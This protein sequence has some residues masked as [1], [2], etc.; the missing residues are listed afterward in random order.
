MPPSRR[1]PGKRRS[2]HALGR[3]GIALTLALL[4]ALACGPSL[5]SRYHSNMGAIAMYQSA[6][7]ASPQAWQRA[8][9]ALQTACQMDEENR[10]GWR[11]LGLVH[12]LNGDT[13][14]AKSA[15]SHGLAGQPYLLTAYW[16][17]VVHWSEAQYREAGRDWR[18]AGFLPYKL[19]TLR[20]EAHTLSWQ[21]DRSAAE[22]TLLVAIELDPADPMGYYTL[23]GLY[24]SQPERKSDAVAAFQAGLDLDK[25]DSFQQFWA[26]GRLHLSEKRWEPAISSLKKATQAN[27]NHKEALA[28]LGLA[29]WQ[30]G[31]IE[32]ADA[33]LRS[34][35]SRWPQYYTPYLYLST[36]AGERG[37][38]EKSIQGLL[39]YLAIA[40]DHSQA[41]DRIVHIL[42]NRHSR[43]LTEWTIRQTSQI[44]PDSALCLSRL[45][46]MLSD[47]D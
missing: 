5:V 44:A 2:Y 33:V 34:V 12:Y 7:G 3:Y 39:A 26:E 17:G 18:H 42:S 31:Q 4:L 35:K 1:L 30:N 11:L 43:P 21:G 45:T 41:C 40:P 24:W 37:D 19:R 16:R 15:L 22:K 46:Q 27:P 29:Y 14:A 10:S 23:G 20:D 36:I 25:S 28:Q 6:H 8:N 32:Q 47:P 13:A 38:A 9:S